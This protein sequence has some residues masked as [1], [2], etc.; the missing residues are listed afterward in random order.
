VFVSILDI[1]EGVSHCSVIIL[2][3][4]EFYASVF[5]NLV[6]SC[7]CVES[8]EDFYHVCSY[9]SF[10]HAVF[11]LFCL[12]VANIYA[13]ALHFYVFLYSCIV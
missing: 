12:F 1:F 11:Q 7:S 3:L 4:C 8:V 2:C 10:L 6:S 13:I 9:V 5:A